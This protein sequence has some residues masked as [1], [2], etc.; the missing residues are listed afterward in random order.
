[1][2]LGRL[3]LG[4]KVKVRFNLGEIKQI[5]KVALCTKRKDKNRILVKVL[6]TTIV[7]VTNNFCG[8]LE[9]PCL[10]HMVSTLRS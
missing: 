1:M 3:A 9:P 7:K 4:L 10:I 5:L 8:F 6:T 2:Q